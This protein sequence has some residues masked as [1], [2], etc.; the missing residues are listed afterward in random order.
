[1]SGLPPGVVALPMCLM[2]LSWKLN[3]PRCKKPVLIVQDESGRGTAPVDP[4]VWDLDHGPTWAIGWLY[5]RAH[6][7]GPEDLR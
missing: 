1:M 6:A 7:C 2:G 5:G 4:V 3:C